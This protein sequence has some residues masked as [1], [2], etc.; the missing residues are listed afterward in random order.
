M[1]PLNEHATQI[2]ELKKGQKFIFIDY[3][4]NKILNGLQNV[5]LIFLCLN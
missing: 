1:K 3:N 5:N 2:N 4:S